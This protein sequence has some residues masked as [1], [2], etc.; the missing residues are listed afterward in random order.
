MDLYI[1]SLL[2][3]VLGLGAMALSGLGH[4]GHGGQGDGGH[5]HHGGD[6]HVGHGHAGHAVHHGNGPD[7]HHSQGGRDSIVWAL[8]S[9]RILF[10]LALGFGATGLLIGPFTPGGIVRAA[11]A[12]LGAVIFERLIVTPLWNFTMR[13]ASKPA[14]TLE[15]AVAD[16]AT[17][18]TAFDANG[19]GIV[20]I[21]VDGQIV[22]ILATLQPTDRSLGV[23]VRAGQRVRIEDVNAAASR[24]TV[25]LI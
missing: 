21:E 9:P 6:A 10:S 5:G 19:Q 18:V 8:M 17:A 12:A 2:L 23:R 15:S 16:E 1:A 3:G 22:Q 13:F 14:L 25:S 11:I 7:A 24:C 20:S 4:Q